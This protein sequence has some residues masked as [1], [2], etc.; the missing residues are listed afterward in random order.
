V[1]LVRIRHEVVAVMEESNP[2][3]K[4]RTEMILATVWLGVL[5]Q[6]LRAAKDYQQRR[7]LTHEFW[8]GRN[9]LEKA[10]RAYRKNTRK[11]R[12]HPEQEPRKAMP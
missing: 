7:D 3:L 4:R 9:T 8:K 11:R 5:E 1:E 10:I 6:R 12:L 2:A